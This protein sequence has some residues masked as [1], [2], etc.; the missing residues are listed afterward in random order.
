MEKFVVTINGMNFLIQ[1]NDASTPKLMGF[2]VNAYV[3]ARSPEDAELKAVDLVRTSP[4]LR[5]AV[6]NSQDDPP[7]LWASDIGTLDEWPA[8]QSLPL[9]GFIFFPDPDAEWLKEYSVRT[10][11]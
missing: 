9:S 7:R 11:P 3:E 2:Y 10:L 5:P 8:D 4:K 6:A 1:D